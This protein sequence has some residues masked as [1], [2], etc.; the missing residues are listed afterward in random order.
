M[1]V[2]G[3]GDRRR[4]HPWTNA[5]TI[6]WRPNKSASKR[7]VIEGTTHVNDQNR[8]DQPSCQSAPHQTPKQNDTP[9]H[10]Y[11]RR[12][13]PTNKRLFPRKMGR[14]EGTHHTICATVKKS[15]NSTTKYDHI[16]SMLNAVPS[17]STKLSPVQRDVRERTVGHAYQTVYTS[18]LIHR[19]SLR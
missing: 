10:S 8:L 11:I 1:S 15:V 2:P 19:G 13:P 7:P 17:V 14:R 5:T 6:I 18:T 4:T 16:V 9:P 12:Q 3:S